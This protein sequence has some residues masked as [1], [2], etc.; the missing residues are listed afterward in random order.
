MTFKISTV[1]RKIFDLPYLRTIFYSFVEWRLFWGIL[2][3]GQGYAFR[4]ILKFTKRPTASQ[5]SWE[6]K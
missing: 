3:W 4:K 1:E 5:D 6:N 2:S